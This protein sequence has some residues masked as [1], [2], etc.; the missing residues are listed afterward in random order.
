MTMTQVWVHHRGE[1]V[2]E[3]WVHLGEGVAPKY[4]G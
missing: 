2:A 4:V 3:V 1:G